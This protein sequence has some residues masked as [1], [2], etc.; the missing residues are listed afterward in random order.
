MS[1]GSPVAV[2]PL[3]LLGRLGLSATELATLA[4]QGF[5][6]RETRGDCT[7]YRLRYR[8]DGKVRTRYLGTDPALAEQVRRALVQMHEADTLSRALRQLARNIG[9]KLSG[10]KAE[11]APHLEQAGFHF[12]GQAIRRR[13]RANDDSVRK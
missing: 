6:G 11:L 13:R 4:T 2:A 9:D 10:V 3:A 5:V 8:V 7:V 12:H 1:E